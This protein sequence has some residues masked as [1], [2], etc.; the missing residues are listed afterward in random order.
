M[1][2]LDLAGEASTNIPAV[3]SRLEQTPRGVK[4][5]AERSLDTGSARGLMVGS[6]SL[7]CPGLLAH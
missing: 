6:A 4:R 7:A 2:S 1:E 5:R 3:R